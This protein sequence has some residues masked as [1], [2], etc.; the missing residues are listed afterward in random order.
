MYFHI[1]AVATGNN[2][3]HC[4]NFNIFSLRCSL[5]ELESSRFRRNSR[6]KTKLAPK[7]KDPLHLLIF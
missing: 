4:E 7:N 1:A 2:K 3:N 6:R 5:S